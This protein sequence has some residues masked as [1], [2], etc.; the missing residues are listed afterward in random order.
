VSCHAM[1]RNIDTIAIYIADCES[2]L[3][4]SAMAIH[5]TCNG[6]WEESR[7]ARMNQRVDNGQRYASRRNGSDR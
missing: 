2:K 5:L 7:G 1:L 4:R 3:P 6:E